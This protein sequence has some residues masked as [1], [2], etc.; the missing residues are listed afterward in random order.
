MSEYD[1][2]NAEIDTPRNGRETPD[3]EIHSIESSNQSAFQADGQSFSKSAKTKI[4]LAASGACWVCGY[5]TDIH[6][7]RVTIHDDDEVSA[8]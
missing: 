1:S 5:T 2:S 3:W 7:R 4:K 6:V 8:A